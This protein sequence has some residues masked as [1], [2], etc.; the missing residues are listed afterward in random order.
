MIRKVSIWFVLL[1]AL[2]LQ[3]QQHIHVSTFPGFLIPHRSYIP[4]LAAHTLGMEAAIRFQ[5]TG[6]LYRDSLL[7][8]LDW[9]LALYANFLGNQGVSGS[10]FAINPFFQSK[11]FAI[12]S[13]TLFLRIGTGVGY[14]TQV[15]DPLTNPANRAMSN[16]LNGMMQFALLHHIPLSSSFEFHYGLGLSH[17][18]NGNYSRPNL[19]INTP[20]FN[21]GLARATGIERIA[22]NNMLE[23]KNYWEWRISH[24]VK[25]ASVADPTQR[26]V[27]TLGITKGIGASPIRF[28]RLGADMFYDR[29]NPY[30]LFE[31][32]SKK[33]YAF[34]D[35]LELGLRAG[36]EYNFGGVLV[37]FDLGYYLYKPEGV[38][39]LPYYSCV[40]IHY[41]LKDFGIGP[42]LKTHAANAD[43]I[44]WGA[45]YRHTVVSKQKVKNP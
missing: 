9:G 14:F 10:V 41:S 2:S 31:P 8:G 43:Y 27:Q 24:G 37:F 11:L 3:G 32:R 18:S 26:S 1:C 21:I 42:R 20:Q 39:K 4:H 25:K 44:D 6:N 38:G 12:K 29:M 35:A 36:F 23:T 5:G 17:F 30:V 33:E 34:S 16:R 45:F 7:K 13:S 22:T 40:G 15:F 28:W 19:G